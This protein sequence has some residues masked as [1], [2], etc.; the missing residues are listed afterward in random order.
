MVRTLPDQGT[1]LRQSFYCVTYCSIRIG[2]TVK[3]RVRLEK[4]LVQLCYVHLLWL[5]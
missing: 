1:S 5:D 2:H 4:I 3:A